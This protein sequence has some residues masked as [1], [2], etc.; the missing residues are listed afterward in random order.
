MQTMLPRK[1]LVLLGVGVLAAVLLVA[2]GTSTATTPAGPTAAPQPTLQ[3]PFVDA[4]MGS[5]HADA[6]AEAFNHWNTPAT[7]ST[8]AVVPASCAKCHTSAGFQDFAANGKVTADVPAPAGTFNCMTCHNPAAIALT[9]VTFPSGKTID[10]L[11]PEARCMQC[12][13]GRESKVSVDKQITTFNVTDVDAVVAPMTDSA[14]KTSNFGF[15]NV[16]YFM[17]GAT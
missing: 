10:N 16:H 4:F 5:A 3:V 7:G 17:G 13:Q 9:S 8:T 1:L 6:K 2:C 14:G 15:R 12:H 11:G